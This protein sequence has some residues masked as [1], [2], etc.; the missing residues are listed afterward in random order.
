MTESTR[1]NEVD[2]KDDE[3]AQKRIKDAHHWV[4]PTMIGRIPSAPQRARPKSRLIWPNRRPGLDGIVPCPFRLSSTA[5]ASY[6]TGAGSAF[7]LKLLVECT[8]V[9]R[10]VSIRMRRGGCLV[11][12]LGGLLGQLCPF[13]LALLEVV[14]HVRHATPALWFLQY[15]PDRQDR[16][17]LARGW[18]V[19]HTTIQ[20]VAMLEVS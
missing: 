1:Q 17:V 16:G 18:M 12:R 9:R 2:R 6:L 14:V 15:S 7:G 5:A 8:R 20:P 19:N 4:A 11:A 13:A 3:A 10:N